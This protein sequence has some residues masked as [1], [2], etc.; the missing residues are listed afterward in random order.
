MADV[1]TSSYPRPQPPGNPLDQI[2]KVGQAADTMGNIAVGQGIQQAIQPDGTIDQNALA[3]V[4]KGSV[5][6]SMKAIPTL[7]AV[8]QLRQAGYAADAAGL[9]NFSTRMDHIGKAASSIIENPTKD[10]VMKGFGYLL[11]PNNGA[12]KVGLGIPQIQAAQKEFYDAKGNLLP[13]DQIRAAAQRIATQA[14]SSQEALRMHLPQT[15]VQDTGQRN[16][17]VNR[18]TPMNPIV[19]TTV[20]HEIPPTAVQPGANNQPTL[21]GTQPPSTGADVTYPN[22][23][24]DISKRIVGYPGQATS[25]GA[26]V[27]LAQPG[28]GTSYGTPRGGPAGNAPGF[29][30]ATE[31]GAKTSGQLAS[32]LQTANNEAPATKAI[33]GNL[34]NES[35]NFT[36]G[37]GADYKRLAKNF[38]LSNAPG[39]IPP[40]MKE[41]GAFFDPESLASQEGFNKNIYNLVQS[42]FKALGGTGTDSKLESASHTSPSELMSQV[43]V[44]NILSLLKGNQDAIQA[45]TK[46]WND[47]QK[48]GNGPQTYPQFADSFNANFDPRVYQ[49]KYMTPEQRNDYYQKIDNPAERAELKRRIQFAIDNKMVKY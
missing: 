29:D 49:F 19:G 38:A 25:A 3:Q 27:K 1:D 21:R 31:A 41:K 9:Q 43:G 8:E 45:K 14:Q 46:A 39:L 30:T 24:P 36:S 5:A 13:P 44:K 40:S 23:Q 26:P 11:N 7:N 4:L 12:S 6:G 32:E 42:Q 34:E 35:K 17:T 16:V 47:W 28:D 18:G 2:L 10:G 33:I 37:S 48:A 15:E 20:Q 22:Q